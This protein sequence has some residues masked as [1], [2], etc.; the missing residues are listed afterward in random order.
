[1]N[2]KTNKYKYGEGFAVTKFDLCQL[3]SNNAL[4]LNEITI[5]YQCTLAKVFFWQRVLFRQFRHNFNTLRVNIL[6][7]MSM[8]IKKLSC[9]RS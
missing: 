4:Y 1:M 9:G 2:N 6:H 8:A 3:P 7:C 5:D